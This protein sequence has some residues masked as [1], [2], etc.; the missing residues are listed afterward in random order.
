MPEPISTPE[1]VSGG[2]KL[3]KG[4]KPRVKVKKMKPPGKDEVPVG[5]LSDDTPVKLPAI[6]PSSVPTLTTRVK[7]P[8]KRSGASPLDDVF[9]TAKGTDLDSAATKLTQVADFVEADNESEVVSFES[10]EPSEGLV[11]IQVE[12][13]EEIQASAKK[14]RPQGELLLDGGPKGK[15]E[16]EDPNL[17]EGEDL[18]IPPF[19]RNKK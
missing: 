13:L 3:R 5:G 9:E 4:R 17:I 15:F 14:K 18:D 7:L 6:S 16:G 11:P 1:P 10:V 19:L 2:K 8:T 12:A